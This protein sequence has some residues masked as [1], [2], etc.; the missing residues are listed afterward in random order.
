MVFFLSPFW[1][2]AISARLTAASVC[3]GHIK[4]LSIEM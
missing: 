1:G 4:F 3:R 2:E